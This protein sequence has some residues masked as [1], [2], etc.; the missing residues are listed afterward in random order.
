M[1]VIDKRHAFTKKNPRIS[2]RLN[3]NTINE[4]AVEIIA[5]MAAPAGKDEL[6]GGGLS[7]EIFESQA[8][9][10]FVD[11]MVNRKLMIALITWAIDSDVMPAQRLNEFI[12]QA[13]S[14]EGR[15]RVSSALLLNAISKYDDLPF[16]LLDELD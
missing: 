5:L 6:L 12:Q 7:E 8:F 4:I 15:N 13:K 3:D 16:E 14:V 2:G 1:T 11:D 9:A 10:H